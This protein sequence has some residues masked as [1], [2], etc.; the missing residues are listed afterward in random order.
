MENCSKNFSV[1][2]ENTG[3]YPH[4]SFESC[5]A[6]TQEHCLGL[7]GER[8]SAVRKLKGI[9]VAKACFIAYGCT[10]CRVCLLCSVQ[11][12]LVYFSYRDDAAEWNNT[13]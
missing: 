6:A 7:S 10:S 11:C 9:Y 5:Q 1:C 8:K 12:K 3:V 4:K 2:L 13:W